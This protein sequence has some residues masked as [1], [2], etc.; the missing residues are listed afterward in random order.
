[1]SPILRPAHPPQ[2]KKT[3][4]NAF[5]LDLTYIFPEPTYTPECLTG[6]NQDTLQMGNLLFCDASMR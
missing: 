5:H 1:M 3:H 6:Q 4:G 2:A